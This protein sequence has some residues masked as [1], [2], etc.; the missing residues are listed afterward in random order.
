MSRFWMYVVCIACCTIILAGCGAGQAATTTNQEAAVPP[1]SAP[2]GNEPA[3]ADQSSGPAGV[4]DEMTSGPWTFMVSEV[5]TEDEA[6]GQVPAPSGQELMYVAVSLY[7]SG[8]TE[9]EIKPE[10][11]SMKDE[12]GAVLETF[13]KRQAY[14]ALDMTP[15]QPEYS[16]TTAFIY[17][18]D[19]GSTGYVFAFAPE[20]D[21]VRTPME[22]KV[23]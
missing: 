22:V 6:P 18:V 8:T 23:R 16:T 5:Y 4:G 17:A 3:P 9:L 20:V 2:V 11:F 12:S 10:D 19:P 15:L 1:S 14:N 13:G 21:G 7:N